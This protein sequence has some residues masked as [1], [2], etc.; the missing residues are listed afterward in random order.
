MLRALLRSVPAR[1]RAAQ[2]KS[3]LLLFVLGSFIAGYLVL[4]YALFWLGLTKLHQFPLIGSLLSQ[5]ILFLIF[6]FFFVMLIFSN[7]IIGYSTLFRN[8]ETAWLLTLPVS[9]RAVYLWKFFESLF[10][11]SWALMFLSAPMMLAYGETHAVSP[12]FY[13]KVLAAYVPFVVIPALIGSCVIVFLARVLARAWVKKALIAAAGAMILAVIFAVKPVADTELKS[14]RD[15]VTFDQL[16]KHTRV[17][18]SPLLPSAWLAQSITG[19]SQGLGRQGTFFFLV[20]LSN[21][22]M[23]AL[24][25]YE[26]IGRF[27]YGSWTITASSR[28]ERF[29]QRAEAGRKR[30]ERISM[31]D[32]AIRF[33]PMSKPVRALV[34]KDVRV[35]WRDP[36]QWTQFAIFFGLLCIYVLNLRNV[37]LNFRS[38]FWETIISHLNL[39]AS[40]LT[41]STLTTRFVF[42]QFSLEGRRLWIL[43]PAPIDLRKVL[44][45]KYWLSFAVSTTITVGLMV[46]SSMMLHLP[47][48]KLLLFASQIAVMSATL[49]GVAVGLGALFPNLKEDNPSKIVSGFGGTFC[50]VVSFIYITC[51]IALSMIPTLRR[52]TTVNLLLSDGMAL[53]L[54]AALSAGVLLIP[55]LSAMRRMKSLEF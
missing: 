7:L 13:V 54:E 11:S 12:V 33:L 32:R 4:G 43:G 50:L 17:S 47:A 10:V 42:P 1:F 19:W 25:G 9:H 52:V 26:V 51:F 18:V 2:R 15:T 29:Q 35:F 41:L 8:R 21:A 16:L 27:F 20:L 36:A 5:R 30:G 14:P 23:G 39:G 28:A 53:L 3:R 22:T 45:Q 24:A 49:C 40:S 48:K 37:A 44:L 38:D 46:T 34:I 31:L 6:G 55:M